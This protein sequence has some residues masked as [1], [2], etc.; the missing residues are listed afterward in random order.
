MGHA[1]SLTVGE[2][3]R[4][5][6]LQRRLNRQRKGSKRRAATLASLAVLRRRLN[7]RRTDWIEQETTTL[8]RSYDLIAIE[9]LAI[10]SMT[11]RP[12]PKPDP[13]KH[14]S[15]LPNGARAKAALNKAILASCWGAFATRLSHKLPEGNLVKVPARNT[16][17]TCPVPECRHIAAENRESQ[18]VFSCAKCGHQAHA[19]TNA[20]VEI[21]HRALHPAEHTTRGP[22][23]ARTHQPRHTPASRVNQANLQRNAA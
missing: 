10:R 1:P 15:F 8:A 3:V 21:L 13:Q 20:A 17:R 7:N 12:T 16:S 19:D 2:Q 22:S 23:G 9:A 18:A 4:F 11:R 5:L 14:G 6:A